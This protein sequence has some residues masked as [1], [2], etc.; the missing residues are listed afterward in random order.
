MIENNFIIYYEDDVCSYAVGNNLVGLHALREGF[1]ETFS[2][3]ITGS[4][5]SAISKCTQE[6]S[7]IT[8]YY[9]DKEQLI[10]SESETSE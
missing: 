1:K 7:I 8:F 2:A 3:P 10:Q 5:S 9:K 4:F 6:G